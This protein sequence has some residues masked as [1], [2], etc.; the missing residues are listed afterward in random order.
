MNNHIIH[1]SDI[2]VIAL[3]SKHQEDYERTQQEQEFT[4][5]YQDEPRTTFEDGK[6]DGELNLEPEP[7]Q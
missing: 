1:Q 6:Y 4:E 2:D 5:N 3:E 7:Y